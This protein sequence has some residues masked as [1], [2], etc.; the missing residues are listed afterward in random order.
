MGKTRPP[1]SLLTDEAEIRSVEVKGLCISPVTIDFQMAGIGPLSL[2][3][4][5]DIDQ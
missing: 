1:N 3:S 4:A 2:P 5:S